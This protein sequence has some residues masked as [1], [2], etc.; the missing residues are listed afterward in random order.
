M[1]STFLIVQSQLFRI[2]CDLGDRID[3]GLTDMPAPEDLL[4]PFLITIV[5][6]LQCE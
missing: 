4:S 5:D 6:K 2:L 1:S 3:L